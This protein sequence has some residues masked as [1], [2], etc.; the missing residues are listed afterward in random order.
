M[1]KPGAYRTESIPEEPGFARLVLPYPDEDTQMV[2][3]VNIEQIER[4]YL[5]LLEAATEHM[6]SH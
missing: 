5:N 1:E 6:E 2:L 3:T 4:L